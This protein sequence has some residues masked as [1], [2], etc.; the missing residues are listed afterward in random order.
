[1]A[2]EKHSEQG[3]DERAVPAA[4]DADDALADGSSYREEADGLDDLVA[5][6][7]NYRKIA[8]ADK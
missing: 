3:S 6:G 4:E 1:M 8:D 2:T 7:S 5:D